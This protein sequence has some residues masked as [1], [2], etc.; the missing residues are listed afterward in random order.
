MYLL[1]CTYCTNVAI[2]MYLLY[3]CTYC[4]NGTYYNGGDVVATVL[5]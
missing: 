2:T 4:T 3:Q 5:C 1:Q